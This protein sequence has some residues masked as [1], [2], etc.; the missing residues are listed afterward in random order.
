MSFEVGQVWKTRGGHLVEI[1]SV[2][3]PSEVWPIFGRILDFR[4]DSEGGRT[5][6]RDG[7][8]DVNHYQSQFD[9]MERVNYERV[10]VVAEEEVLHE[11]K[12]IPEVVE[13]AVDPI[14]QYFIDSLVMKAFE[15]S[16]T[17]GE[18]IFGYRNCLYDAIELRDSLK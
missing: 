17:T 7:T 8:Y 11:A 13:N 18:S 10:G 15:H 2:D 6:M 16:L 4:R 14:R 12:E 9:L 3:Y 1:K 5:F